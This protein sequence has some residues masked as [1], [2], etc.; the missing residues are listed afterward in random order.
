MNTG[1]MGLFLR[2]LCWDLLVENGD[3]KVDKGLETAVSISLFT[4]RRV[5]DQQLPELETSK[6]GWWGDMFPETDNDQIGS[7]LWTIR[8]R[9][10]TQETLLLAE[11]YTREA[12]QW[13]IEDGVAS[14]IDV[15]GEY[16]SNGFLNLAIQITRPPGTTSRFNVIW[17]Q[18]E[19]VRG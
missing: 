10:R 11:D 8:R 17:E 18:Q 12:L 14:A 3:L 1:D 4:H 9:K 6:E 7:R 19:L 16:D 5:T 13:L 2:N 15:E